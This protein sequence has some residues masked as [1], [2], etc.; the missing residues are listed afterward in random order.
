MTFCEDKMLFCLNKKNILST[1][2]L[3][4]DRMIFCLDKKK[5]FVYKMLFCLDKKS[6]LST[7]PVLLDRMFF[8]V[9]KIPFCGQNDECPKRRPV[10]AY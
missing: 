2:P 10:Y 1:E 8:Y 3:L 5:H 6:I 4:L 7:K 9:D